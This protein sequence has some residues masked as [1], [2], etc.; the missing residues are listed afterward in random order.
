[1]AKKKSKS[2]GLAKT[3]FDLLKTDEQRRAYAEAQLARRQAVVDRETRTAKLNHYKI[4]AQWHDLMTKAKHAALRSQLD[5]LRTV[6]ERH[7]DRKSAGLARA[8]ATLRDADDQYDTACT[9]HLANVDAL[10][11]L[12]YARLD[13]TERAFDGDVKDLEAEFGAERLRL[14]AVHLKEKNDLLGI[15]Y[16]LDADFNDTEADA[17]HEY[18]SARDDVRN[19][20]LEEKHALRI[21]LEGMIEDLWK[22]FQHA[23]ANYAQATDER[24]RQFE[25]LKAKDETAAS[26]IETQL[27]KL[28]KLADAVSTSRGRLAATARDADTALAELRSKKERVVGEFQSLKR[29]MNASRDGERRR[30]VDLTRLATSTSAALQRHVDIAEKIIKMA[31]MNAKLETR[32]EKLVWAID[33]DASNAAHAA[34]SYAA[35]GGIVGGGMVVD[36]DTVVSGDALDGGIQQHHHEDDDAAHG[37]QHP[38]PPAIQAALRDKLAVHKFQKRYNK[39]LLDKL[40]LEAR[41]EKLARENEALRAV[42]QAYL[43]GISVHAQ[44]L[45]SVNPLMVV[46][47]RT[48]VVLPKRGPKV[49]PVVEGGVAVKNMAMPFQVRYK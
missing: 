40:A 45:D 43:D 7:V 37:S 4:S 25:D 3:E 30:M 12:Q 13:A 20:N 35:S 14:H 36:P 31:E 49:I 24:K 1:M 27:R 10:L 39:V 8:S 2:A 44:T 41:R 19:K 33:R 29:K 42:L 21:Q 9:A 17:R 5:Q 6:H 28:G 48:N 34:A 15:V 38:P 47:G 22:Q 46:N 26:T 23:L 11:D 16:R 18:Q 32:D